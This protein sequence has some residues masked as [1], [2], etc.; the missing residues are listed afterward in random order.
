MLRLWTLGA[1]ILGCVLILNGMLRITT[2][3]GIETLLGNDPPYAGEDSVISLRTY[4]DYSLGMLFLGLGYGFRQIATLRE[5]I[6]G[7]D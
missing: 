7:A 2:D 4:V 3:G 1:Q 6:N 5:K